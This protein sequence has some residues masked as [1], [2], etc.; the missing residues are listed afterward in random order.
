MRYQNLCIKMSSSTY[1][2]TLLRSLFLE[3]FLSL[4][5]YRLPVGNILIPSGNPIYI[6]AL[7]GKKIYWPFVKAVFIFVV[8]LN[9]VPCGLCV[10]QFYYYSKK[11]YNKKVILLCISPY[12]VNLIC[13]LN[14][15]TSEKVVFVEAPLLCVW[16]PTRQNVHILFYELLNTTWFIRK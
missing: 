11:S 7:L 10:S 2:I 12:M 16:C 4:T 13:L 15:R 1:L 6:S 14:K 9:I 3:Q 8:G 5:A